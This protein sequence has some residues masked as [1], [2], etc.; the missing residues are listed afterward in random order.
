M[1]PTEGP[2]GTAL[3]ISGENF[4]DAY[5]PPEPEPAAEGQ[6]DA[7]AEEAGGPPPATEPATP[8][9]EAP[10]H[11]VRFGPSLVVPALFEDGCVTCETPSALHAGQCLPVYVSFEGPK[12]AWFPVGDFTV[13]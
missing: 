1:T 11:F 5:L 10:C 13:V 4:P 12:G 3:S 8:R 6:E 9:P 2:A 7:E